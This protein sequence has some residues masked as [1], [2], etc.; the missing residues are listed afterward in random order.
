MTCTYPFIKWVGTPPYK[1]LESFSIHHHHHHHHLE[2]GLCHRQQ[3][4]GEEEAI[5]R[6]TWFIIL[7]TLPFQAYLMLDDTFIA[8]SS[9]STNGP[10]QILLLYLLVILGTRPTTSLNSLKCS[11]WRWYKCTTGSKIAVILRDIVL[12]RSSRLSVSYMG[13]KRGQPQRW[14]SSFS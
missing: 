12:R 3:H 4:G 10:F 2:A 6:K 14:S 13:E 5:A 9:S 11:W 8:S 1:S 7:P